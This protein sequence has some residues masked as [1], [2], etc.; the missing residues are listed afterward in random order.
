MNDTGWV[1]NAFEIK[2]KALPK[3]GTTRSNRATLYVLHNY[4]FLARML[5]RPRKL[6][7]SMTEEWV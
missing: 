1:V 4:L 7:C 3:R 6:I 5:G 2:I